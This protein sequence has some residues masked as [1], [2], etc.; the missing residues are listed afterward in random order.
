MT[1]Y[2]FAGQRINDDSPPLPGD[3]ELSEED[4]AECPI[5]FDVQ[6]GPEVVE[7]RARLLH[8]TEWGKYFVRNHNGTIRWWTKEEFEVIFE[9]LEEGGPEH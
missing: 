5:Y 6:H 4:E 1:R 9:K 8:V 7:Q 3:W 2:N